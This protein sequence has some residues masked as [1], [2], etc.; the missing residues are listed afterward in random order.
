MSELT[1]ASCIAA[2][3]LLP[4]AMEVFICMFPLNQCLRP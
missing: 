4:Q 1:I 3:A 2:S